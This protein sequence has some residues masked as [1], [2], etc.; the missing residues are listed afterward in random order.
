MEKKFSEMT[1]QE[2]KT[3]IASLMEKA[4]KASQMGY[5]NEFAVLERKVV[6]AQSYLIDPATIKPGEMYRIEG[7]PGMFFQVDYLKG[8]F[9][10]GHRLGGEKKEEAL[11]IAMLK[12]LKEGK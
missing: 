2:I 12:P 10:W 7:D 1:E 3:E 8:R 11:P 5:I 6:M 4:K 9:A